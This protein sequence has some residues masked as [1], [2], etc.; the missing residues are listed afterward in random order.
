MQQYSQRPAN[1]LYIHLFSLMC[2]Y[3]RSV[4]HERK[5]RWK[6]REALEQVFICLKSKMDKCW[7]SVSQCDDLTLRGGKLHSTEPFMIRKLIPW[8]NGHNLCVCVWFGSQWMYILMT[9]A[10]DCECVCSFLFLFALIQMEPCCHSLSFIVEIILYYFVASMKSIQS[11]KMWC[12]SYFS[13]N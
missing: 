3:V 2:V 4:S 6:K 5:V 12:D 9:S 11:C 10:S 7:T 13:V 8:C 1:R